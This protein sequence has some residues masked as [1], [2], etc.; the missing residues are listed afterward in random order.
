MTAGPGQ[1]LQE[2]T[3]I[4][5]EGG[6]ISRKQIRDW[7]ASQAAA[8]Q[9]HCCRKGDPFQDPRVDSCLTPGNELS[10]EM[11]MLTKQD[12]IGKGRPGREQQGKGSQENCFCHVA[13][14]LRFYGNEV[15]FWVVSG[16]SS[17]SA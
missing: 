9:P 12:F 4:S 5:S 2:Y 15:C 13:H 10:E 6:G 16:Q 7:E 8:A 17:C 14:S 3:S 11:H 1:E